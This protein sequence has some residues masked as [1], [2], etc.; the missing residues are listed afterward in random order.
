M[1][2]VNVFSWQ[3]IIVIVQNDIFDLDLD[4][5]NFFFHNQNSMATMNTI[6]K[7]AHGRFG[8]AQI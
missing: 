5:Y 8:H 3:K 2:H 4:L 7:Y 6:A 1:N